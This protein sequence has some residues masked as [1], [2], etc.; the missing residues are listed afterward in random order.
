MTSASSASTPNNS[1]A[2]FSGGIEILIPPDNQ[3]T[4]AANIYKNQ[5]ALSMPGNDLLPPQ[6]K[7]INGQGYTTIPLFI[8]PLYTG[9]VVTNSIIKNKKNRSEEIFVRFP[10]K[11]DPRYDTQLSGVSPSA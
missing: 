6:S 10:N 11:T 5:G 1:S 2:N 9:L 4:V 7:F 8:Y 3:I